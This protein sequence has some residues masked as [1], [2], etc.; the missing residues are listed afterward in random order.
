[1]VVK[2]LGSIDLLSSF[3][4]LLII[5]GVDPYIQIIIFCSG[6]SFLKGLFILGGDLFSIIDLLSAISLFLSIFFAMPVIILWLCSF[7]LLSK[8]FASFL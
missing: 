3:A 7:L 8:S 6:L 2:L 1:M 5:F 4:F